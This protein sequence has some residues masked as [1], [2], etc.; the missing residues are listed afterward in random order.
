[1]CLFVFF[2]HSRSNTPEECEAKYQRVLICSLKGYA[3]YLSKI[4]AEHMKEAS[5]KNTALIENSK[6]WSYQKHKNPGIRAA[7]FETIS[8]LL[9][10]HVDLT[11]FEKQIAVAALQN[12]DETETIVLPHI[13]TAV[14]LVMQQITEWY[15]HL[16]LFHIQIPSL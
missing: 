12:I 2:L 15:N 8:A 9:Q 4:S 5:N 6:F 16:N 3:L 11:K 13:W 10:S 7:W 14:L 1:M